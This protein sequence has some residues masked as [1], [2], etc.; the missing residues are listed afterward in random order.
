V[1]FLDII[2]LINIKIKFYNLLT[3]VLF[4]DYNDPELNYHTQKLID[5]YEQEWMIS[6][7]YLQTNTG[8]NITTITYQSRNQLKL[9]E[10]CKH[11]YFFLQ[12]DCLICHS[13]M[14][15]FKFVNLF[16]WYNTLSLSISIIY[17]YNSFTNAYSTYDYINGNK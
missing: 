11:Y 10:K 14:S 5:A 9:F 8:L 15:L 6:S 12:I 3:L 7:I 4:I 17:S 2:L 13:S 1:L 16:I